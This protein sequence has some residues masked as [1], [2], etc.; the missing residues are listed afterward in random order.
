MHGKLFSFGQGQIT[1]GSEGFTDFPEDALVDITAK[2]DPAPGGLHTLFIEIH[3]YLRCYPVKVFQREAIGVRM[4]IPVKAINKFHA[5]QISGL[6]Y[7]YQMLLLSVAYVNL[8]FFL[9][10]D[11][12]EYHFRHHSDRF[13][14]V[15]IQ[16]D[17]AYFRLVYPAVEIHVSPVVVEKFG[18]FVG[19]MLSG[20]LVEHVEHGGCHDGLR[21][22]VTPGGY[23]HVKFEH[24]LIRVVQV[25]DFQSVGKC[26]LLVSPQGRAGNFGNRRFYISIHEY[27]IFL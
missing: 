15:F 7:T 26:D 24:F 27:I 16:G 2:H 18:N 14:G 25:H 23:Y 10:E 3:Q 8:Q 11:A 12:F 5:C 4:R 13:L 17:H 20:A 22:I 19:C 1:H 9:R 21:L 6:L